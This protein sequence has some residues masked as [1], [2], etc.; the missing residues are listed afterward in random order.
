M[1]ET[2]ENFC[3][4]NERISWDSSRVLNIFIFVGICRVF[5]Y[6][7]GGGGGKKIRKIVLRIKWTFPQ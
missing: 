2:M 7:G 1:I 5:F 6:E 3:K 4:F